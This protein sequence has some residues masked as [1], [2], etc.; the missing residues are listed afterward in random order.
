LTLGRP[1]EA[2]ASAII[3]REHFSSAGDPPV[4]ALAWLLYAHALADAGDYP[5]AAAAFGGALERSTEPDVVLSGQHGRGRA[6]LA[7]GDPGSAIAPLVEAVAGFVAD[8]NDAAAAFARFDLAGA[9]HGCGQWLDAAETAEEALPALERLGAQ[10][11]ADR[12]RYLLSLV[13]RD[14][15]QPDEAL[16]LLD[17][18]V[19]DLD[20][21]DNP[22]GAGPQA[23]A[24]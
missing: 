20:R 4:A 11:A 9:Y 6:F 7:A 15:D 18:L 3:A 5:G 19:A 16:T 8:G 14:L 2:A 21:D 23:R 13:Y 1:D 10:D 17:E 22:A 12:C 24:G